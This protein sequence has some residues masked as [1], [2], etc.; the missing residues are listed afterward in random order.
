MITK[1][2]KTLYS[3]IV[4]SL[5][6]NP[7]SVYVYPQPARDHLFISSSNKMYYDI[8]I[9]DIN[10]RVLMKFSIINTTG[11]MSLPVSRLSSGVYFINLI[12]SG[13]KN[14][15]SLKFIKQ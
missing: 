11:I 8:H 5:P 12:E 9:Y 14:M 7:G 13:G 1:D 6:A 3:Q 15:I 4:S 2:G 10:G